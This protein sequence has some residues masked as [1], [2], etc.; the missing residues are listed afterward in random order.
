MDMER[1]R[2]PFRIL[3]A[4]PRD[5]RNRLLEL[6]EERALSDD[7]DACR[8]ARADLMNPGNRLIA[9]LE[10]MPQPATL[11]N[12][13]GL[14]ELVRANLLAV[15]FESLGCDE[16][17]SSVAALIC[18]TAHTLSRV[19]ASEVLRDI[20]ADRKV[21]GFPIILSEQEVQTALSARI[22]SIGSSVNAALNR[23]PTSDLIEA[24]TAAAGA[25]TERAAGHVLPF[26][27]DLVDRHYEVGTRLFLE[28][29]AAIVKTLIEAV[30][31][32][33]SFGEAA[34][35]PYLAKLEEVV[36][37]WQRVALPILISA[38]ARGIDYKAAIDLAGSVRELGVHLNNEHFMYVSMQRLNTLLV[39]CFADLPHLYCLQ[40]D[41]AFLQQSAPDYRAW[42]GKISYRAEIGLV[43]KDVLSICPSG[44]AWNSSHYPLKTISRIRCGGTRRSIFGLLGLPSYVIAFGDPSRETVLSL[45]DATIYK[46]FISA[47]WCAVGTRLTA[48]MLSALK[49]G[50]A[51]QFAD[52]VVR[53]DCIELPRRRL[54]G[55][56]DMVRCAWQ[57]VKTWNFDAQCIIASTTDKRRRVQLPCRGVWNI[58]V[59]S[60]AISAAGNK[61]GLS[62]LSE[63]L[64]GK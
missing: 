11:G 23:L 49:S 28:Q 32:R 52:A 3:G 48:D 37:S 18:E 31:Q 61:P 50:A 25:R 27:D 58:A 47:L 10:W 5:N 1:Q 24:M 17:P 20:N 34:L 59:L 54:F 26:I 14:P 56:R 39:A 46:A 41:A 57:N 33:A 38:K 42:A 36:R 16:P 12:E 30:R 22:A 8:Q 63:L 64:D 60:G 40:E 62:K 6:S 29:E 4:T 2:N 13:Q 51:L 15:R 45:T 43:R 21:S 19:S 55:R 44:L 35:P 9:E 7:A 53:D